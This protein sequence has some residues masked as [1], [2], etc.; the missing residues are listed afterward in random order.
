MKEVICVSMA[1]EIFVNDFGRNPKKGECDR[2]FRRFIRRIRSLYRK[3]KG[4]F[5]CLASETKAGKNRGRVYHKMIISHPPMGMN[6]HEI[7]KLW[8]HGYIRCKACNY[9]DLIFWRGS[10]MNFCRG[11]DNK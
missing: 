4:N 11:G 9:D 6:L 7:E 8:L 1:Y 10:E 3:H 2:H 5:V